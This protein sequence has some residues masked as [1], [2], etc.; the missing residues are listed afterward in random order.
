VL[1]LG[2]R[3]EARG[4]RVVSVTKHGGDEEDRKLVAETARNEKMTY[5]CFLDTDGAWSKLTGLSLVPVFLV[6]DR[7]GRVA[8][9]HW[10]KLALGTGGF[11]QMRDAIELALARSA[12]N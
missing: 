7:D 8:Y 12:P 3:Y 9:R 6:V 10:G 2:G 11:D 1:E 4:L 5:P